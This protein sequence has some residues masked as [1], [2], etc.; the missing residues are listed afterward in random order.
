LVLQSLRH[1]QHHLAQLHLILRQNA[2]APP[3]WVRKA[4]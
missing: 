2:I 4:Y 1:V 3:R